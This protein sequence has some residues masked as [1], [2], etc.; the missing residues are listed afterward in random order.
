MPLF[1]FF[2][3]MS[4]CRHNVLG[5]SGGRWL[6]AVGILALL[7]FPSAI[8]QLMDQTKRHYGY[9][10]QYYDWDDLQKTFIWVST[11][12]PK[13]STVILPP[14][15]KESFYL[16][17]R[18]TIAHWASPRMDRFPEW[19]ER[20][21]ALIGDFSIDDDHIGQ[22]WEEHYNQLSEADISSLVKKYGG[23]YL[24]SESSYNYPV[25]FDTGTYKVYSIPP[26]VRGLNP[27]AEPARG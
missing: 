24:I 11:N 2:S 8:A 17:K 5:R 16:T 1:F 12:T 3:L 9:F 14:W 25:V 4:A 23:D 27:S 20:I 21:K 13:D 22:K 18:A 15:R 26:G 7:C 6:L 19:Q 10:T